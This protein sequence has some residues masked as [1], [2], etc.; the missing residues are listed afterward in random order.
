MR[1]IEI[2]TNMSTHRFYYVAHLNGM[3]LDIVVTSNLT[4][5]SNNDF[6]YFSSYVIFF[7]FV[8]TKNRLDSFHALFT[9]STAVHYINFKSEH[10]RPKSRLSLPFNGKTRCL[11]VIRW[12]KYKK[13]SSNVFVVSNLNPNSK[14]QSDT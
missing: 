12:A 10:T 13:W 8:L 6:L 7:F 3:I 1:L 9:I 11:F 4:Q 14:Q 2:T 5:T